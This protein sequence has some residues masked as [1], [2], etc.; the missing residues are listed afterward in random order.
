MF[1][2]LRFWVEKR[3]A[4]GIDTDLEQYVEGMEDK[5]QGPLGRPQ[6]GAD[7]APP[8]RRTNIPKADEKQRPLGSIGCRYPVY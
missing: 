4:S 6:A 2:A 7:R 1:C 8:A 5:L 3:A